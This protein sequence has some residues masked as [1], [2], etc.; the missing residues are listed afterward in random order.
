MRKFLKY[1]SIYII[2][3]M[4]FLLSLTVVALIPTQLVKKNVEESAKILNEEEE[5]YVKKYLRKML[6]YDNY[7]DAIMINNA[8]SMDS[9]DPLYSALVVRRNYIPGIT[10]KTLPE[11]TGDPTILVYETD[12]L[13]KTVQGKITTAKQYAKYWHGYLVFLKPLLILFNYKQL[14]ILQLILIIGLASIFLYLV[15]KKIGIKQAIIFLLGFLIIDMEYIYMSLEFTP[16][17]IL[18]LCSSITL[19]VFN[20]KI[21][22]KGKIFFITGMLSCFF[23]FLTVPIITLGILLLISFLLIQKKEKKLD[24]KEIIKIFIKNC[25][26]WGIGYG[27][28]WIAKFLLVDIIYDQGL[29][30]LGIQ[31]MLHRTI[32]EES[33]NNF[34]YSYTATGN[35]GMCN[36]WIFTITCIFQIL[37]LSIKKIKN[38]TII[39][40]KA[41]IVPYLLTAILPIIWYIFLKEHSGRHYFFTY[42]SMLVFFIGIMISIHNIV[43]E[44]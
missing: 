13:M 29:L 35:I 25:L 26:L 10:V 11:E 1:I 7:T 41:K 34:T 27:F 30:K 42:R 6:L 43:E 39:I 18:M 32:G 9:S 37:I 24:I 31:Q 19:V 17:F 20:N 2:V 5:Y 14:R 23:D 22:D 12:N 4:I 3:I 36:I 33:Y 38:K 21:K 15:Y 44:K 16:I 40:K 28:T 8:Y